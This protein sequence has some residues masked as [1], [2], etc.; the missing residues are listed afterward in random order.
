M[1]IPLRPDATASDPT[2]P[3]EQTF[4]GEFE[5]GTHSGVGMLTAAVLTADTVR[6]RIVECSMP[7]VG[8]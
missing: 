6:P 7:I 8:P 3:F 5:T 2:N 4:V 1:P